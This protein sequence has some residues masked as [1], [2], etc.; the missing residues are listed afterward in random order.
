M[1]ISELQQLAH[2]VG[3]PKHEDMC[4]EEELIR[5]IQRACKHPACFRTGR[6]FECKEKTCQWEK[7]CKRLLAAWMMR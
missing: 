6:R 4:T 2:A 1:L 3:V 7:E 5:A